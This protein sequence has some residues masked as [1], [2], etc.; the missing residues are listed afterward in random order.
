MSPV[1]WLR[2]SICLLVASLLTPALASAQEAPTAG[3]RDAPRRILVTND[4]GIED[5]ATLALARALAGRAEVVL[6]ASRTDRSGTST[7]MPSIARGH[8]TVERRDVGEAITAYAVDG[9]PADGVLFALAGPMRDRLPDLVVSG[10]NGGSNL[11]DA[12]IG[13]GTIGAAR[14]AAYM[15]VPAVAI[16]GVE[17]DDPRAVAAAVDWSVRL[18]ESPA[19]RRLE[20]PE[21]LTVSLP[22]G[23]PDRIRGVTMATRARGMYDVRAELAGT[24][25]GGETWRL[26]LVPS[27][28]DVAVGTDVAAVRSGRIAVVPMRA[29]EYDASLA[30]ALRGEASALPAWTAVEAES[31]GASP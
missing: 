19:V 7:S 25:A 4:N 3:E 27:G 28:A 14:A 10:I 20:A 29:G 12:W 18:I 11:A 31:T 2:R 16:S 23:P 30:D 13:S 22:V 1:A 6:V 17:D 5:R 24:E 26:Q 15:G 8:L 9:T 21:Y